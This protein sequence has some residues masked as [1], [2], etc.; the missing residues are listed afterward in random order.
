MV[1]GRPTKYNA[2]ID[3]NYQYGQVNVTSEWTAP[4]GLLYDGTVNSPSCPVLSSVG[5][6]SFP[7][8][9]PVN[10]GT[11]VGGSLTAVNAGTYPASP[12]YKI[13]GPVTN[14]KI[15][16]AATGQYIKV[17]LALQAWDTL[18]I[19]TKSRVIRLNGVNCNSALDIGSA[20]FTIPAGGASLQF[21]STG[22]GTAS[23]QL[24][25]YTL[26]TYSAI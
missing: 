2:P 25:A 13:T 15:T 3:A 6:A 10:F 22:A 20:F 18:T 8:T 12:V 21:I 17:N 24:T 19:D 1:F 9:F 4:D 23:G 7:W 5:N 16:N 26:N 14:P 11:S